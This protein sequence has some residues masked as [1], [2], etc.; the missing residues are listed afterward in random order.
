LRRGMAVVVGSKSGKRQ[1]PKL[2]PQP[3]Y[4]PLSSP[5]TTTEQR[6]CLR[7]MIVSTI[8]FIF[9]LVWLTRCRSARVDRPI[10]GRGHSVSTS[11]R[12][13]RSHKS[14]H[15]SSTP[16]NRIPKPPGEAGRKPTA[17]RPRSPSPDPNT[18][19]PPRGCSYASQPHCLFFSRCLLRQ[20]GLISSLFDPLTHASSSSVLSL[21]LLR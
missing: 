9:G 3:L 1:S 10:E 5:R 4:R 12:S 8:S 16:E 20:V 11:S 14:R 13:E 18:Q 7:I 2:G 6:K 19:P 17:K 15:K 21:C